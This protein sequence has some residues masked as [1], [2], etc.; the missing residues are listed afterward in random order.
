MRTLGAH[1]VK[2]SVD[3][4]WEAMERRTFPGVEGTFIHPFDNDDFIAGSATI[5]LEIVEDLPKVETV[6]API[7]GGGLVT[8]V[9]SG[10]RARKPSVRVFGAEPRQQP[11]PRSPLRPAKRQRSRNGKRRSS[12]AQA[13]RVSFPGCGSDCSQ[14]SMDR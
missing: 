9:A 5:G 13:A 3:A 12:M 2:V 10:V 11:R 8:G 4:W 1:L 14:S 7:G 6:I